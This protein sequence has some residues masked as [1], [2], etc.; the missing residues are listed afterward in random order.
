MFGLLPAFFVAY[1]NGAND[2]FKTVAT[3]FG[4]RVAS[5][6]RAL[7]VSTVATFA[8]S[9]VAAFLAEALVK[10]FSGRSLVPDAVAG[11]PDFMLAVAL[12]AAGTVMLATWRGLPV[13]TTH[14]IIGALAGAGA[15]A[16]GSQV[17]AGAL[18]AAFLAPLLLSPVL[19]IG[20]A[21]AGYKLA[22]RTARRLGITKQTCIC[23]APGR[24]VPVQHFNGTAALHRPPIVVAPS[25][26]ECFDKYGTTVQRM[27]DSLHYFS[28]AAVSFARGLND[29]P[30]IAALL[31][32][33]AALQVDLSCFAVG[34]VMALGGLLSG[35]KVAITMSQKITRLNDGQALV[36]NL[37]TS[38]LVIAASRYGLPVSTTHV[39]VGGL[40]GIGIANRSLEWKM[41]SGIVLAWVVTLPVAA[42]IGAMAM[43][44]IR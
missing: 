7:A 38:M 41:L 10:A 2:N 27:L 14:G 17:S 3:L 39:S 13:S 26:A 36:A 32:G 18:A 34:V 22:Q 8:G 44:V 29:T 9:V 35:R 42:V 19:A 33:A 28:A 31:V 4:S 24:F 37:V 15:I 12:G 1:A 11:T 30:K 25:Q 40:T 16:A 5:Y 43:A 20:L 23:V 6:P 21:L